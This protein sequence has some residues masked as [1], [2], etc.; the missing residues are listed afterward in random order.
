M[1]QT[2]K[3]IIFYYFISACR[4]TYVMTQLTQGLPLTE[5]LMITP[6]PREFI[7]SLFPNSSVEKNC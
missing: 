4:E 7:I 1:M 3:N 5:K 6:P 2:L